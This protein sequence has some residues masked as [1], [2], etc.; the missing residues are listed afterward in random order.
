MNWNRDKSLLFSKLCV[1]LFG[2]VLIGACI[3]APWLVRLF[4]EQRAVGLVEKQ[5]LFLISIYTAAIPAA[6]ALWDLWRLLWNLG[7]SQVFTQKNV[8]ILR[9][10]SWYC[11]GVGLICLVSCVYYLPFLLV[12]AAAA[13]MGLILRVV[14]NVFAEAIALKNENDY[15]I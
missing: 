1:C 4:T 14:K 13:F 11:I 2:C 6:A 5:A 8:T 12:S 10:L 9:R 7:C 15:T 3:S